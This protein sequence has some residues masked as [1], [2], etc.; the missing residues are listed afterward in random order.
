MSLHFCCDNENN[1][2]EESIDNYKDLFIDYINNHPTLEE[3]LHQ[4]FKSGGVPANEID[5]YIKDIK[6]N[7]KEFLIDD[8]DRKYK[9]KE[10]YPNITVEES[11]IIFSY[12]SEAKDPEFSPYKILNRNLVSENRKEGLKK[13]SKY[14]Y[15]L[16]MAIRK[17]PKYYPNNEKKY[18]YRCINVKVKIL[19]DHY[20]PKFIPYIRG[21]T[22][23]FWTFTSTSPNP[24]TSIK[25]LGKNGS[26]ENRELKYGTVFSLYGMFGDMI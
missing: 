6:D 3:A 9:I 12:T 20:N 8:K 25:F 15:L 4:L 2:K 22:K 19:F 11:F 24:K 18:L 16:L 26:F 14:L 7:A 5:E 23:T 13:I 1:E 10:K 17:L 21:N